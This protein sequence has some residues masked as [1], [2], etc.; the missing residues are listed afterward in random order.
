MQIDHP[1]DALLS[2][3]RIEHIFSRPLLH[4]SELVLLISYLHAH[5][6][7]LSIATLFVKLLYNFVLLRD[8]LLQLTFLGP[9]LLVI[10]V[11]LLVRPSVHP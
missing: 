7:N 6:I 3:A 11:I 2:V 9:A 10:L 4:L 5:F 1:R 8:A